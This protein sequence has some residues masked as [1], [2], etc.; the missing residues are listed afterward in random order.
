MRQPLVCIQSTVPFVSRAEVM[1]VS[2]HATSGWAFVISL[3]QSKALPT[4]PRRQG[5]GLGETDSFPS[6]SL[7]LAPPLFLPICVSHSHSNSPFVKAVF[8]HCALTQ[9]VTFSLAPLFSAPLCV[10]SPSEKDKWVSSSCVSLPPSL[11]SVC[12]QTRPHR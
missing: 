3:H 4:Q 12:M 10:S 8:S 9:P 1:T 7:L 11:S 5:R 2:K 6:L